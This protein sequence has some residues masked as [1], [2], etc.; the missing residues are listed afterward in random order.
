MSQ[1]RTLYGTLEEASANLLALALH[2][3]PEE[4]E[5]HIAAIWGRYMAEFRAMLDE[6]NAVACR[7]CLMPRPRV[8]AA[9]SHFYSANECANVRH[10]DH[11]NSDV[12]GKKALLRERRRHR[13]RIRKGRLPQTPAPREQHL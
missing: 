6:G 1:L 8:S 12:G 2:T 10:P 7:R 11:Y 3:T 9:E 4:S 5:Q 13:R